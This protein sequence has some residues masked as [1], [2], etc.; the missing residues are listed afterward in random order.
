MTKFYIGSG[1]AKRIMAGE[2]AA[3][4]A[5]KMGLQE[6]EDLTWKLNVQ[7]GL[8]TEGLNRRFYEHTRQRK[9]AHAESAAIRQAMQDAGDTCLHDW[10]TT[11]K[12][13]AIVFQSKT[14]DWQIAHPDGMVQIDGRWGLW[15]SKHTGAIT[16]FN[17][18]QRVVRYNHWQAVHMM[19]VADLP[20]ME[21]SVI[22]GNDTLKTWI[23]ERS[24]EDEAA[25]LA[26][27][28][29][30]MEALRSGIAPTGSAM[31]GRTEATATGKGNWVK[32]YS[33]T[34]IRE[35]PIANEFF[36]QAADFVETVEQAKRHEAA[37]KA[38]KDMVP[39]DAKEM[40][41]AG[42][43]VKRSATGSITI[44]KAKASKKEKAA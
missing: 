11:R 35:L 27:E 39:E 34:M 18:E 5:E 15:D 23:I 31:A 40:L 44:A 17:D 33:E 24:I 13:T 38:I 16:E 19:M 30:F 3:L 7:M 26:A 42:L 43:H 37:K 4:W 2:Q 28:S 12:P 14:R 6:R 10:D 8:T 25:L 36:A 29:D 22:Y 21:L 20:F 41:G 32:T 9:V 1:D